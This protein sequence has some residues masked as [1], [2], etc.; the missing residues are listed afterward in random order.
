MKKL[1]AV[2]IGTGM[3]RLSPETIISLTLI[4]KY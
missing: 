4:N 1:K 2:I 3:G